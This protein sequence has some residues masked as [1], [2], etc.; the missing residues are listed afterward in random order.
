MD[1]SNGKAS[2]SASVPSHKRLNCWRSNQNKNHN[3]DRRVT[4]AHR[5]A[6]CIDIGSPELG[7]GRAGPNGCPAIAS[8]TS[9]RP[10]QAHWYWAI[11]RAEVR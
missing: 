7:P 2:H 3:P 11:P 6:K 10:M 5:V 8:Q 4:Q 1:T 9:T